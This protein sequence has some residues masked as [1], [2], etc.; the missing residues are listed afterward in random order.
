MPLSISIKKVP[1]WWRTYSCDI[2]WVEI[3]RWNATSSSAKVFFVCVHQSAIIIAV[4]VTRS[5]PSAREFYQPKDN[6]WP[7]PSRLSG[8]G[9]DFIFYICNAVHSHVAGKLLLWPGLQ[10]RNSLLLCNVELHRHVR[11][12]L[13]LK[14]RIVSKFNTVHTFRVCSCKMEFNVILHICVC[15]PIGLFSWN[16]LMFYMTNLSLCNMPHLIY[17]SLNYIHISEKYK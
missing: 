8:C 10:Y 5:V 12:T 9:P 16:V 3:T 1:Y 11:I 6:K 2:S 13:S 15:L 7:R 17:P 14:Y 4:N